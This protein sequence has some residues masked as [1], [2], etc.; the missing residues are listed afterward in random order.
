MG[1]IYRELPGVFIHP[2]ALVECQDIGEGTR[3]WAFV[4]VLDG[5]RV[6]RD[7]NVCD[8]TFIESGARLGDR[9]TVKSGIYIWEG[10]TCED[11]VFLGPNVVFT[12]D[13]YPRSKQHH[14]KYV[15]TLVRQGAS[16][17]ANATIL[18]GTT[19]GRYAL[20]GVGS[21]VTRDVPDFAL[22]YG[23]PARLEG[24]VGKAGR[25]LAVEGNIGTCPQTGERYRIEGQTC[26]PLEENDG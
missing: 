8:Y 25:P 6:G 16:I 21:V 23:N 17:G 12:N 2:K 1:E 4:H 5:C 19:I 20:I 18:C 7:C 24:F 13:L 10:V 9:V 26:A 15:A 14:E 22:A 3:V 11:D